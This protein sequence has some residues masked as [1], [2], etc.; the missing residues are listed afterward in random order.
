MAR[1]PS[2]YPWLKPGVLIGALL[3]LAAIVVEAVSGKLGADPVAIALNRLGL[4]ALILLLA[5]LSATPAR[6]LFKVSWPLRLR[7]MLG[8][9][10]FFYASLHFLV[11]AWVDQGWDLQAILADVTKRKFITVGFLALLTLLPLALTSNAR[12]RK[13]LG[14]RRWQRLHRLVYVAACLA[15]VHFLWRVKRDLTEPLAYAGVLGLLLFVR[16]KRLTP[17]PARPDRTRAAT[18]AE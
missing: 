17:P 7:R 6:L 9:L 16:L 8:L 14:P 2:P 4:L 3:P 18:S 5:C 13:K 10:A 1:A 12:A 15:A 11:Y